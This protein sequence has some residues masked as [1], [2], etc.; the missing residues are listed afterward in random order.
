ML[1]KW[2]VPK[3]LPQPN[4][5]HEAIFIRKAVIIVALE[6]HYHVVNINQIISQSAL[7]SECG[8]GL[9]FQPLFNKID[10][11]QC[12]IESFKWLRS[13]LC[14]VLSIAIRTV[15]WFL[16]KRFVSNIFCNRLLQ[17]SLTFWWVFENIPNTYI[18]PTI[19]LICRTLDASDKDK[20]MLCAVKIISCFISFCRTKCSFKPLFLRA[21]LPALLY[22]WTRHFCGFN[23]ILF[24]VLN[25]NPTKLAPLMH[26]T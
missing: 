5:L 25:I 9:L 10:S 24:N 19:I 14:A 12:K 4:L 18:V 22:M 2:I 3:L 8:S 15:L 26:H 1:L 23:R 11:R 17:F 20:F 7:V 16:L 21:I 13:S 6:M